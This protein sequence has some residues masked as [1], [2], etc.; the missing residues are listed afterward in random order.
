LAL[1]GLDI[2]RLL[3]DLVVDGV[4]RG[5]F[6][7]L[8]PD[9]AI[10]LVGQQIYGAMAVRAGEPVPRPR[11]EAAADTVRFILHGLAA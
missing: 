4:A 5:E 1:I 9:L 3:H 10:S 11:D 6:R 8:D 2:A 7:P